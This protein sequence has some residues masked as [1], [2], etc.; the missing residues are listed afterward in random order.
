L[1][2]HFTVG[3]R[4]G[5]LEYPVGQGGFTMVDVGNDRKISDRIQI[6]KNLDEDNHLQYQT[7][8]FFAFWWAGNG[9]P[10]QRKTCKR[11]SG[12]SADEIS[13]R[14]SVLPFGPEL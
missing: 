11:L 3:D 12:E 14:L 13:Q 5:K 2:L 10:D 6:H 8:G 4:P 1:L 7:T 9:W